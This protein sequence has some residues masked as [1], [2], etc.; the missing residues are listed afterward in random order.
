MISSLVVLWKVGSSNMKKYVVIFSYIGV[1]FSFL[2]SN[3]FAFIELRALFAGDWKLYENPTLGLLGYIFRSLFYLAMLF[4]AVFVF[5]RLLN[6][7]KLELGALIF[8]ASLIAGSALGIMFY[9]WYI[10]LIVVVVNIITL[11]IRVAIIQEKKEA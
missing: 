2:L 3:V 11:A 9:S 10:S 4:N 1:V 6:R 7:Q 5:I 8:N